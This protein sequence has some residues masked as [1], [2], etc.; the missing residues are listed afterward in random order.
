MAVR[1]TSESCRDSSVVACTA[2][3]AMALQ[4]CDVVACDGVAALHL[5][6]LR[7]CS[8]PRHCSVAARGGVVVCDAA[9][10]RRCSS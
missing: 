9:V 5:T 3:T 6:T 4:R 1:Q 2:A 7:G 10:L 8:S